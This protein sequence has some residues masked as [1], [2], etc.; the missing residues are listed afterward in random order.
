MVCACFVFLFFSLLRFQT[1]HSAW[2]T[3]YKGVLGVL[4]NALGVLR[5]ALGVLPNVFGVLHDTLHVLRY[6]LSVLRN[7]PGLSRNRQLGSTSTVRSIGCIG[8]AQRTFAC[9][10]QECLWQDWY[11][12]FFIFQY[13]TSNCKLTSSWNDI[14]VS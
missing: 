6:A 3:L 5:N 8:G 7:V 10:S 14:K 11:I 13:Q 9:K 1:I 12:F 4:R 2:C